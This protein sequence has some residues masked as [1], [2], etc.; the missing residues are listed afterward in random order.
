MWIAWHLE[1]AGFAVTVQDWD[2]VPGTPWRRRVRQGIETADT[3]LAVVSRAYLDSRH[4]REEWE[5]ARD[6]LAAG[7]LHRLIVARTEDIP[8]TWAGVNA[9]IDLFGV[10]RDVARRRLLEAFDATGRDPAARAGPGGPRRG[11]GRAWLTS[12]LVVGLLL[13]LVIAVLALRPTGT[14]GPGPMP[15]ARPSLPARL[16]AKVLASLPG[17]RGPAYALAFSRDGRLLAR[18]GADVVEVWS[19]ADPATP[20]QLSAIEDASTIGGALALSPDGRLLAVRS[21]RGTTLLWDVTDTRR[22]VRVATLVSTAGNEGDTVAVGFSPDGRTLAA[23]SRFSGRV[24]LWDVA[25]PAHP[26]SLDPLVGVTADLA[27]VAFSPDG[28]FLVSAGN[29]STRVVVWKVAAGTPPLR[30][31]VLELGSDAYAAAFGGSILATGGHEGTV[32][33]WTIAG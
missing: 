19:V 32:T 23:A 15:S 17:G 18:G 4:A 3:V 11:R 16:D 25:D 8:P 6:A 7:T 29:S 20:K 10:P 12:V 30:L 26:A 31:G 5:T 27:A 21:G 22:Q 14:S 28:R 13:V 9:S 33:L 1:N 24:R 2:F